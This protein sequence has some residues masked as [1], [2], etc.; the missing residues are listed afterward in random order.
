MKRLIIAEK[1][2]VAT[3]LSKAIGKVKKVDD[4]YEGDDL[5]IASAVGHLVELFMPQDIDPKLKAWN[6]K[7][8][9]IV[10]ERFQLKPIEKT[11]KKFNSL[12]KL[13]NRKDVVEVI[14]ACDAGREGE[15][16]FTYIYELAACKK[17]V[18]RMW[19]LSMTKDSILK[20]YKDLRE[21][22]LMLP[23]QDAAR[24]RSESDWLIGINGT[25]VITSRLFGFK[26][27]QAA[28]VGR[29]QTPTL[30]LVVEREKEIRNFVPQA[31]W[32]VSGQFKI[33]AGEYE[34]V[35]QRKDYKEA[36][37]KNDRADRF[38]DKEALDI[39]I[40]QIQK[41]E[42][43]SIREEKKRTTQAAPRLYDLTTLQREANNR[44]GL[45]AGRTLQILQSLYEKH[46][47]ITY[48][49]TDS[50]ALPEDYVANCKQVL[51]SLRDELKPLS[52]TILDKNWVNGSNKRIFNNA[53][54][55]DHFAI[56][57]TTEYHADLTHDEAKVYDMI[58][59]R[60]LAVFYPSAEY[61]VTTRYSDIDIYSFKTEGKVLVFPGWLAVYGKEALQGEASLAPI[62]PKDGTPPMAKILNI[63][64][65]DHKTTPPPHYSEATLLAAMEGAG[66]L[67]E[68][69]E[70][71][72]AMKDKGLGTPATRAQTIDHL[73][74]E[75]YLERHHRDI[76]STTKAEHLIEF[77]KAIQIEA[78]TSPALTGEWEFKLKQIEHGQLNRSTFMKGIGELTTEIVEKARSFDETSMHTETTDILSP[79]D[80]SALL[81]TIRAYRSQDG[82]FVV[83][84]V[85][86]NRRMEAEEVRKL[87]KEG[88]IGPLDGF[89]SKQGKPFSAIL[90]LDEEHK[91]RFVFDAQ[92]IDE[93]N[94][95]AE[96]TDL[97]HY[98]ALGPCPKCTQVP[99]GK[100]YELPTSYACE[101]QV[102]KDGT[103][104]FRLSRMLLERP[105]EQDQLIKLLHDKKTDLLDKFRS[106]RT[107]R[108]FSAHLILKDKGEIGFEFA[109]KDPSLAKRT[110]KTKEG[111]DAKPAKAAKVPT[112]K[113]APAK[114][115]MARKATLKKKASG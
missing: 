4:Y 74:Y 42:K 104:N 80:G 20:A 40:K 68:D 45:P 107:G 41:P 59:R 77:L 103:C 114:A 32:R 75:K 64:S 90:K 101:H 83:N 81:D 23:L 15:L 25:R 110:V 73:I 88:K 70:L 89:R 1:P 94:A 39:I 87:I 16:I 34:G 18:K 85:I 108:F 43:A 37:H 111:S 5:I 24:C 8:L 13:L 36:L 17:P 12:K 91:V 66:K 82:N 31:Y 96:L 48:P 61:D 54:V 50:N 51:Q 67:V 65:Q 47:M 78:L 60:F 93:A 38:W 109:A 7:T 57:P 46:K 19:M 62:G 76:I 30:A 26:G 35:L 22:S 113:A 86:A 52:Q 106:K 79:I 49:R 14:N 72:A 53:Q 69:E 33:E 2:S 9:P 84:K 99:A 58:V 63:E 29:V 112:K 97:D 71:S 92:A 56:I 11:S 100:V 10:P 105:I 27:G 102:K 95:Q 21:G 6:L 98:K 44:F 55:S 28:T 115:T 3:D